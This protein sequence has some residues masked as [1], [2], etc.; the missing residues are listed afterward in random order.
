MKKIALLM[1]MVLL[2]LSL[3]ACGGDRPLLPGGTTDT[4]AANETFDKQVDDFFAVFTPSVESVSSGLQKAGE[5]LYKVLPVTIVNPDRVEQ[6]RQEI[7]AN[8]SGK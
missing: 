5:S 8:S 6:Y 1:L 3:T 7:L 2:M 4:A